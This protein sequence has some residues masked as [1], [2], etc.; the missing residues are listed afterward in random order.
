[1]KIGLI[2]SEIIGLIRALW[3]CCLRHK[4]GCHATSLEES[5]KEA[6]VDHTLTNTYHLVKKIGQVDFEIIELRLK[7]EKL[8]Q[9]KYIARS[10]SLPSGLNK[11]IIILLTLIEERV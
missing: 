7:K 11:L 9:A 1:M 10:A 4:I 6:R 2:S 8:T 3:V 5:E